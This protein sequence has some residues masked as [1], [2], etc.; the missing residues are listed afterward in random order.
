MGSESQ[1]SARRDFDPEYMRS[2]IPVLKDRL[3]TL[4]ERSL[5]RA[6]TCSELV[7]CILGTEGDVREAHEYAVECELAKT[8]WNS[9]GW[10]WYGWF[11][12]RNLQEGG[13]VVQNCSTF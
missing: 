1:S 11:F 6:S 4:G 2:Q 10:F 8:G 13:Q 7:R 3:E 9:A 5:D 12:D